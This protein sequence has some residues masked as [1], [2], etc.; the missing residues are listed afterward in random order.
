M[1]IFGGKSVAGVEINA[2]EI[3]LVELA[4][5]R[6]AVKLL[7]AGSKALPEG[8]VKEGRVLTPEAVSRALVQLWEELRIKTRQ[9]ILGVS[10]QDIL[11]RFALFP[12]V[13]QNKLDNLVRFQAQ[14]YLPISINDVE[15]D[16]MVTGEEKTEDAEQYRI[17]LVAG[18]KNMINDFMLAFEAAD[19][20]IL[21]ID[22]S[23]LA[24]ARLVPA[25]AADGACMVV[26]LGAEQINILILSASYPQ[27]ARTLTTGFPV[28]GGRIG[29]EEIERIT[30]VLAG[31][32]RA[33][34]GY[35]QSQ[36]RGPGI[37]RLYLCGCGGHVHGISTSLSE[38]LDIQVAIIDPFEK[39][40]NIT[41]A[42]IKKGGGASDFSVSMSLALRGLEA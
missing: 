40:N 13:P 26:N 32:I 12:K 27:L 28:A 16:Y 36:S 6:N 37:D 42:G 24:L 41:A 39:V 11:V 22:I 20:K 2:F 15:L 3:R 23:T 19:L 31:E 8:A 34:I 7:N 21:D 10:N 35:F 4:G 33:S 14:E 25:E 17:L 5:S 30:G 9:V 1:G 18:R 38:L 29:Q